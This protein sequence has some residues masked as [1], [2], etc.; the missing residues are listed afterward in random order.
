[1]K[2]L[3]LVMPDPDDKIPPS[4][5]GGGK[6]SPT[7]EEFDKLV[8]DNR[9]LKSTNGRLLDESKTFKGKFRDMSDEF[10]KLKNNN[11][12]KE[13]NHKELLASEREKTRR[14]EGDLIDT[15]KSVVTEKLR[16]EALKHAKDAHNIDMVLKVTDHK[17]LL[18]VDQENL[19]V[20]GVEEFMKKCRE[21]HGF[22][23]EKGS[24]P[25]TDNIRPGKGEPKEVPTDKEQYKAELAKCTTEKQ[26]NEV[27][28]KTK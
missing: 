6:D 17:D 12:E 1:M 2:G 9:D 26:M 28:V 22:L 19:S 14:L 24:L 8:E 5:D 25:P 11:L 13:G 7:K 16:T 4:N 21:T 3:F 10:D 15:R 27:M 20:S 23:F 18:K